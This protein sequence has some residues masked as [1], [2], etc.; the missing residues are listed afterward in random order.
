MNMEHIKAMAQE[1]IK[2]ISKSSTPV[3]IG[4]ECRHAVIE[5]GAICPECRNELNIDMVNHPSHY[6][7]GVYEVIK[8]LEHFDKTL[9]FSL[10]NALK[11]IM[12]C[13][14]KG[15][16]QQDLKKAIFYIQRELS[17]K[18]HIDDEEGK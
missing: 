5:E 14:L 1:R 12:R 9:S 11:Y 6:G 17:I 2:E 18:E 15:N 13:E 7:S 4:L 10:L 16:K 8:I 3:C